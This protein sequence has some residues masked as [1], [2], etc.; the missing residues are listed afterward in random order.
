MKVQ[1]INTNNY[2]QNKGRYSGVGISFVKLY[3]GY[4]VK[5]NIIKANDSLLK[6]E[7]NSISKLI[8]KENLHKKEN[9]DIVLQYTKENGFYG[10]ISSKIHGTP[11]CPGYK[12]NI[13]KDKIVLNKFIEWV[14]SWDNMYSKI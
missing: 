1:A 14:K 11:L 6:K 13:S 3:N 12:Q 10:V 2:Q 8:R 4:L 9:V 7:L 5:E